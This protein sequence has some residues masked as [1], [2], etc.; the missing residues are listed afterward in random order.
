M[1]D[2]YFHKHKFAIEVD[3][4]GHAGRNLIHETER[5]KVLEKE[6]SNHSIK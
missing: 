1:I 3:K 2:L 5:Q 6:K 4:L